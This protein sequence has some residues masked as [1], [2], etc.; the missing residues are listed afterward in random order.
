MDYPPQIGGLATHVDE[1]TQALIRLGHQVHIL[2]RNDL[3]GPAKSSIDKPKPYTDIKKISL[4]I[5]G[6]LQGLLIQRGIDQVLKQQP[7]AS[8]FDLI[9]MHGLKCL[10]FGTRRPIPLVFTNHTSGFLR[11]MEKGGRRTKALERR[12]KKVDLLLA[13]STEL[14]KIP[15]NC[16]EMAARH[17]IPNG[18]RPA[19]CERDLEIRQLLRH[20]LQLSA[21]DRLGIA[22][23]RLVAKNGVYYLAKAF[24]LINDNAR[25]RLKILILGSGPEK[26]RIESELKKTDPQNYFMLDALPRSQLLPWYSAADFAILPSLKEATSISGLEAMAASLPLIGTQVG[27]TPDLVPEGKNGILVPPADPQALANALNQIAEID[28]EPLGNESCRL[29]REKFHWDRIA[30]QTAVCYRS[31]LKS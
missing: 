9:H 1:L 19:S 10:E 23:R 15:G 12:L 6:M 2:T 17:Y 4:K 14:L 30:E 16:P 18:I 27:G 29:A 25:K 3:S 31:V 28:L 22:T 7:P 21:Q 13:P 11:R 8:P 24:N 5:P 26:K 20:K